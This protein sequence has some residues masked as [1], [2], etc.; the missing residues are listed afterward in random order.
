MTP[1]SP[2][3]LRAWPNVWRFS[4][5][6]L[7]VTHQEPVDADLVASRL[8]ELA[9]RAP[10]AESALDA[11]LASGEID[12]AELLLTEDGFLAAL[13]DP[14]DRD[15]LERRVVEARV[16]LSARFAERVESLERRAARVGLDLD[17][18]AARRWTPGR[19]RDAESQLAHLAE[20][21]REAED[22][23]GLTLAEGASGRSGLATKRP[24]PIV[25]PVP[26]AG[27]PEALDWFAGRKPAPAAALHLLPQQED[28]Q[29]LRLVGALEALLA[30]KGDWQPHVVEEFVRAFAGLIG[31]QAH[32]T[33]ALGGGFTARLR[34]LEAP[35]LPGLVGG[36]DGL[37]MWLAPKSDVQLPV[38]LRGRLHIAFFPKREQVRRP[39]ALRLDALMLLGV[40]ADASGRRDRLLRAFARDLP[41][42]LAIPHGWPAP[43]RPRPVPAEEHQALVDATLGWLDLEPET[44]EVM[45][46]L[47]WMAG[48]DDTLMG[49]LLADLIR[50][51]PTRAG[52]PR[53]SVT[54]DDVDRAWR[55]QAVRDAAA[56]RLD[57]LSGVEL[58][59]LEVLNILEISLPGRALPWNVVVSESADHAGTS[60]EAAQEA[61]TSLEAQ[62][63]VHMVDGR[64]WLPAAGLSAPS[65]RTGARGG[66]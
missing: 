4:D 44:R 7:A 28:R 18:S 61:L 37:P 3:L 17:L 29:A 48:G 55:G 43:P 57:G 20:R 45:D 27:V 13:S 14:A 22:R 46:R 50:F 52:T 34:G 11:L 25:W 19:W 49:A 2:E 60:M 56:K 31:A 51:V 9:L 23:A 33:R 12:A 21:C 62:R 66:T 59:T 16:T 42:D 41:T 58:A 54:L 32:A 15:R 64:V 30:K 47:A 40:V 35:G 6:W 24:A 63:L 53:G 1:A 26:E 65:L 38:D 8:A 5:L 10:S 39:P 36:D